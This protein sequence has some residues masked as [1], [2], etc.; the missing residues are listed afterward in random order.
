MNG[1]EGIATGL[2]LAR[3]LGGM[4]DRLLPDMVLLLRK[5]RCE[6]VEELVLS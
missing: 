2:G 4:D 6:L 1:T 3:V 5:S